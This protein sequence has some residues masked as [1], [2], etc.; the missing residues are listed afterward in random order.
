MSDCTTLAD[1]GNL[2]G[3]S[4]LWDATRQILYW[5]DIVG[6][7]FY[8]FDLY[9]QRK[10]ILLQ[11]FEVCGCA[12]DASGA[13]TLA[14][15]LGIWFW[16]PPANPTLIASEFAGIKLQINDCIAD[17]EGRL[18]AG[19]AFYLPSGSY[20]LGSLFCIHRN[21]SVQILDEGFHLA[22]GLGFSPDRKTLYFTDSIQRRIY[23]YSYDALQGRVSDRRTFVQL[24][25]NSGLPDGL[26]VDAEG[27]VWSAEWYGGCVCRYDPDGK[28]ERRISLPA[29]QISSL[30]FG[31][32][33]LTDIF[34]TSAAKPEAMPVMPSGYDP[35]SGCIGGALYR[36]NLGIVGCVEYRTRFHLPLGTLNS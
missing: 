19:S 5:T 20:Q 11:D 15:S 34:V 32:P 10:R 23:A 8:A 36:L 25:R 28:L 26:T 4:P 13:I 17:P 27:H 33:D 6:K 31:G 12:L 35:H 3:E 7:K 2:C 22:N 9:S 21:G 24:H 18:L 14:N 16:R 1:D 29:K 30:A